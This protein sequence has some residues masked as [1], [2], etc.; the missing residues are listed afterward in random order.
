[1]KMTKN[2]LEGKIRQLEGELTLLKQ[3]IEKPIS[4]GADERRWG[5]LRPAVKAVRRSLYRDLYAKSSRVR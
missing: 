4:Y 2:M 3:I 1:M 5:R